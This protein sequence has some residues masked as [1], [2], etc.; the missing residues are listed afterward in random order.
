MKYQ[1]Q[2]LQQWPNDAEYEY[3]LSLWLEYRKQTNHL[4]ASENQRCLK[5]HN[6]LFFGIKKSDKYKKAKIESSRVFEM[7]TMK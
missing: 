6:E 5:I 1:S 4:P 7:E 3:Y 2:Y